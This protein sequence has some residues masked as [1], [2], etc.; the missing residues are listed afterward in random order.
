[1]DRDEAIRLLTGGKEGIAEW[2]GRREIMPGIFQE[3]DLSGSSLRGADLSGANLHG[4]K[5]READLRG[6]KLTRADLRVANLSRA[7]LYNADLSDANLTQAKLMGA[8]LTRSSLEHAVLVGSDLLVADLRVANLSG[9]NLA[10]AN[11]SGAKLRRA[12]LARAN[13]TDATLCDANL[14]EATLQSALMIDA[15]LRGARLSDCKVFGISVWNVKTDDHTEQK[16]LIISDNSEPLLTVDNLKIAQFI[17]LLLNHKEIRGV[18]DTITSKVILILGR[19]TPERKPILDALREELRRR[20]YLPV[21]FDFEK[22]SSRGYTE[23]ITT[24]ARMARFIVADLTD[25][26]EVRLE[27]REIVPHLPSVPVQPLLA[28]SADA[29]ITFQ[30]LNAYH[31]VLEPFRYRDLEHAITSLPNRVLDPVE[32]K[33]KQLRG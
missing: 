11:L 13:F 16:N 25:A 1:M 15:D 29:Y 26:T 20:D 10:M 4:A 3:A 32:T 2:N 33:L 6:A 14:K 8:S 19:F 18:I 30:D 24:L 9:A 12:N 7:K 22:P 31:W 23:T 28:A 17:Y 27:L 21:M 5:L